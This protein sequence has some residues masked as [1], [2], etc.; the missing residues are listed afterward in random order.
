MLATELLV[1]AVDASGVARRFVAGLL[2]DEW[3]IDEVSQDT[4]VTV[5]KAVG[6]FKGDARFTTWLH[7]VARNRAVDHLR[8][9]RAV[10]PLEAIDHGPAARMSSIIATRETVRHVLARIPEQYRQAVTLRDVEGLPYE[11]VAETLGRNVN[12]VKSQVARGR[13]LV[14]AMLDE[15]DGM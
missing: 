2:L 1:E 15:S 8:R 9:Q 6:T 10:L 4:L 13:A 14:A 11:Q 3:A 5:A 7:T 12:T